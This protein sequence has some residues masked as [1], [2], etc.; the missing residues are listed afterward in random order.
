MATLKTTICQQTAECTRRAPSVKLRHFFETIEPPALR[1]K[2]ATAC[3][4]CSPEVIRIFCEV[5]GRR[6]CGVPCCYRL[7]EEDTAG[8]CCLPCQEAQRE[9]QKRTYHA[10]K[11]VNEQNAQSGKGL[12][13]THCS[14]FIPPEKMTMRKRGRPGWVQKCEVC[15]ENNR[16]TDAKRR[17]K[18]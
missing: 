4:K 14:A 7:L 17:K 10:K 5:H 3:E 1:E 8:K 15:L 18:T 12:N 2:L 11:E 6:K 13:C 9:R 16:R